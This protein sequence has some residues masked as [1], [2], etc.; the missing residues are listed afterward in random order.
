MRQHIHAEVLNKTAIVSMLA[1]MIAVQPAQ[2]ADSGLLPM[3][4]S[5]NPDQ[6][7]SLHYL[8]PPPSVVAERQSESSS[9]LTLSPADKKQNKSNVNVEPSGN[10]KIDADKWAVE[11]FHKSTPSSAAPLS[12]KEEPLFGKQTLQSSLV[13]ITQQ[14]MAPLD[15]VGKAADFNGD[16]IDGDAPAEKTVSSGDIIKPSAETHSVAAAAVPAPEA[17]RPTIDADK[18]AVN[19]FRKPTASADVVFVPNI[20]PP[21]SKP[22]VQSFIVPLGEQAVEHDSVAKESVTHENPPDKLMALAPGNHEIFVK[23]QDSKSAVVVPATT[24]SAARTVSTPETHDS[25]SI[26]HDPVTKEAATAES[27]PDK[28]L[29]LAP[30]NHE[31]FVEPEDSKFAVVVPETTA[32]AATTVST[33]ET[34]DAPSIQHDPVAKKAATAENPPDKLMA[35]A[36]SSHDAFVKPEDTKSAMRV[37]AATGSAATIVSTRETHDAPSIQHDPVTNEAATAENSPDKLMALAPSSHDAFVK[38]ED[39]KPAMRVPATTASGAATVSTT[40]TQDAPS[41]IDADKWAVAHYHLPFH[42]MMDA[43]ETNGGAP[44]GSVPQKTEMQQHVA[45][46]LAAAATLTAPEAVT[47]PITGN[48]LI[49]ADAA[50]LSLD[51]MDGLRGG[52]SDPSGMIFNFAVDVQ[53]ALNGTQVFSRS[54]VVSPGAGGQLQATN[55]GGLLPSNLPTNITFTA[56]SNGTGVTATDA[57]GTTTT[58]LNQTAAGAPASIIMNTASNRTVTQSVTVSLTLQNL[59]PLM[60][61]LHTASPGAALAQSAGGRALGFR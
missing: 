49:L 20:E 45:P 46:V 54:L 29:A 41:M 25:T 12:T 33:Q 17:D 47:A 16:K 7:A 56:L 57:N 21:S 42:P 58:I 59:G 31:A 43:T 22:T 11:H 27:P 4:F 32:S 18:W 50:P 53:T 36:P 9:E 35:L 55:T 60:N 8:V 30:R 10:E 5:K 6:F 3:A 34:H 23:P 28:L 15:I 40:G 19:H 52:F 38:P 51:D 39:T 13:P 48:F 61:F 37:P 44:V 1:L 26:Q 14:S 24:A 2:S